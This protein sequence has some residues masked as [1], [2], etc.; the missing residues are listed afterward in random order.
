M[1]LYIHD[2]LNTLYTIAKSLSPLSILGSMTLPSAWISNWCH[3]RRIRRPWSNRMGSDWSCIFCG[4]PWLF[5][6]RKKLNCLWHG[7]LLPI[8]LALHNISGSV[9]LAVLAVRELK[10]PFST[11][12]S[13]R[14]PISWS[15]KTVVRV[16]ATRFVCRDSFLLRKSVWL[17]HISKNALILFIR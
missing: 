5:C 15:S 10:E 8:H 2:M 11:E 12:Q 4:W 14:P 1:C 3:V 16:S 13:R 7:I 6:V 17:I 9:I